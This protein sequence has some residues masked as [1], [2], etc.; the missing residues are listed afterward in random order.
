M[1]HRFHE[2]VAPPDEP[3]HRVPPPLQHRKPLRPSGGRSF[4]L[5]RDEAPRELFG[6]GLDLALDGLQLARERGGMRDER[7]GGSA[8]G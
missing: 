4:S 3:A 1:R 7:V 8:R 6:A 5:R 2:R